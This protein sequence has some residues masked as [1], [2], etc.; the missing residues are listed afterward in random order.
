MISQISVVRTLL[1]DQ[2]HAARLVRVR[3]GLRA[4]VRVRISYA[5][6]LQARTHRDRIR[7]DHAARAAH[8]VVVACGK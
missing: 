7:T 3:I 8:R 2:R 4:R 6:R 5:A 1:H